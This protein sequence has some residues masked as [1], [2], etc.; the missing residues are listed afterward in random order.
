MVPEF[1]L[2]DEAGFELKGATVVAVDD[3]WFETDP[4]V[5]LDYRALLEL[6][7]FTEPEAF[8]R[9]VFSSGTTG[10]PKAVGTP[11]RVLEASLS[12]VEMMQA[13]P[14]QHALRGLNMMG[15]STAGSLS[16]LLIALA[17]GGMLAFAH[18][19]EDALRLIRAFR[20]EV[21]AAA[22]VQLRGVLQA[23]GNE[24]PPPSL[25]TV[26]AAGASIPAQ[27]LQETRG[28][29]CPNLNVSYGSSEAGAMSFGTGAALERRPG[30]AGYVLPWVAL[31]AVDADDRPVALGADGILRVRSPEQGR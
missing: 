3:S 11:L 17:R 5:P 7:G 1:V 26:I 2:S 10:Y 23:L 13:G 18:G 14:H 30:S 25:R 9:V 31:E 6:P 4:A 22:V 15:F 28:R 27:L 29:L 12:H 24:P 8:V 16:A 19:P 21:L 20:I